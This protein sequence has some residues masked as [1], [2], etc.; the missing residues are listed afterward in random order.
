MTALTVSVP[1]VT[2]AEVASSTIPEAVADAADSSP[3]FVPL[4]LLAAMF[5]LSS[6]VT[7]EFCNVF[8]VV[9]SYLAKALL[10]AEPGPD[11]SPAPSVP[12]SPAR[13][14]PINVA[15]ELLNVPLDE[16]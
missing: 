2:S 14:K 5:P 9:P 8:P 13:A 11:K 15:S 10:V 12:L 1:V 6:T 3:V 7:P 4:K 16:T